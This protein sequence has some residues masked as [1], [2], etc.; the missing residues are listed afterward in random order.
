MFWVWPSLFSLTCF[1][2]Y[3]QAGQTGF[4]RLTCPS[5]CFGVWPS[6]FSLICLFFFLTSG[7][8][9]WLCKAYMSQHVFW[10]VAIF[11][12]GCAT[13]LTGIQEF[14]LW[15]KHYSQ[16]IPESKAYQ[17]LVACYAT[18]QPALSVCQ[19]VGPSVRHT[20]LF[21]GFWGLW[22]YC[23]CPNDGVASNMAQPTRTRLR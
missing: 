14:S 11:V 13:A 23:P 7:G 19:S 12:L 17:L 3:Y 9:D 5:F 6:L 1:F 4:V 8:P 20:L 15:V 22:P 16:K 2:F 21:W 10:G 18:L